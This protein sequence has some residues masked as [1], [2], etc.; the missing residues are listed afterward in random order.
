MD[1]KRFESRFYANIV[2]KFYLGSR[3]TRGS[4]W[5]VGIFFILLLLNFFFLKIDLYERVMVSPALTNQFLGTDEGLTRSYNRFVGMCEA[6]T[7]SYKCICRGGHII[8]LYK[9]VFS[10]EN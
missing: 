1:F 5:L 6:M 10:C 7:R 4:G 3:G 8:L 2:T 9:L